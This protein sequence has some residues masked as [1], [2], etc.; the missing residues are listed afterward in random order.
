MKKKKKKKATSLSILATLRAD[1]KKRSYTAASIHTDEFRE[2]FVKT[3]IAS[4]IPLFSQWEEDFFAK[5]EGKTIFTSGEKIQLD[6]LY[7][8]YNHRIPALVEKDMLPPE[9]NF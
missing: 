6:A 8:R 1:Q 7:E 3:L 2:L 4:K 9:L 5:I